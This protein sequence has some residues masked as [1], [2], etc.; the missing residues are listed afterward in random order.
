MYVNDLPTSHHKQ[1]LLFQFADDT[2]QWAFSLNVRFAAKLLQQDLLNLAMWSVKW[3]IK[4]NPRKTKVIIFSRSELAR[5]TE[6]NLKLYGETLKAY[7]QLKFL[8][9]TSHPQLTFQ[10]HFEDILDRHNTRYHRLVTSQPKMRTK[11]IHRN[12]NL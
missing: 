2:A 6:A 4:P 1:N 10:K 7:P 5:T 11:P 9:I 12:S 3:R 8:G